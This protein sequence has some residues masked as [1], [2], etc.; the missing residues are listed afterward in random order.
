MRASTM[1]FRQRAIDCLRLANEATDAYVKV[2]LTDLAAELRHKAES[3]DR[4]DRQS[5]ERHQAGRRP[6]AKIAKY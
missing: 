3:F 4:R 6:L 1:E 5:Q 2:A